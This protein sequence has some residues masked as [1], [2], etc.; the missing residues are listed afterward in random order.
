MDEDIKELKD[1][2]DKTIKAKEEELKK[3]KGKAI[4]NPD[5]EARKITLENILPSLKAQREG[6]DAWG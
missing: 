3:L 2:A 1:C 6:V 4:L 5:E